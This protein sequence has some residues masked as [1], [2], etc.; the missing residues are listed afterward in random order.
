MKPSLG[1]R[2]AVLTAS[3]LASGAALASSQHVR[4]S[5]PLGGAARNVLHDAKPAAS[6]QSAAER[7]QAPT[8]APNLLNRKPPGDDLPPGPSRG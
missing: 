1:L 2:S 6:R 4:D 5:G 7:S 3:I 8:P